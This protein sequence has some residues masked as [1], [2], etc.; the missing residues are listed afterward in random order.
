MGVYA[1]VYSEL[2][3]L[4]PQP[5]DEGALDK[6]IL[7]DNS[8]SCHPQADYLEGGW[9]QGEYNGSFRISNG[10]VDYFLE[11]LCKR[12]VGVTVRYPMGVKPLATSLA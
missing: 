7:L 9:Y 6:Y 3:Y 8:G 5:D 10:V 4:D 2:T 1:S 11:E 12:M